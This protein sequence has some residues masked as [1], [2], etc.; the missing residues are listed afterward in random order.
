M[1]KLEVVLALLLDMLIIKDFFPLPER[2]CDILLT[3]TASQYSEA[4][5]SQTGIRIL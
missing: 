3:L 2:A 1:G 5:S 4:F